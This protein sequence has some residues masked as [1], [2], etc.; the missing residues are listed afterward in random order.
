MAAEL[1][2][3]NKDRAAHKSLKSFLSG[4]L[5]KKF[6]DYVVGYHLYHLLSCERCKMIRHVKKEYCY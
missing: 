1:N 5:R 6:L 2:I 3:C 4:P